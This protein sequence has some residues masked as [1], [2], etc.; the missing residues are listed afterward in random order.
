MFFFRERVLKKLIEL[1]SDVKT[2]Y[3][4]LLCLGEGVVNHYIVVGLKMFRPT[5]DC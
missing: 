3:G 5:V 2:Y 1:V 4:A